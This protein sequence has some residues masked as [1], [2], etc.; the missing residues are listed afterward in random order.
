MS[1]LYKKRDLKT[2]DAR[3]LLEEFVARI[4][5]DNPEHD[6]I[7]CSMYELLDEL[8]RRIDSGMGDGK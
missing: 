6:M 4:L 2:L 5:Y 8:G 3:F 7:E 1:K